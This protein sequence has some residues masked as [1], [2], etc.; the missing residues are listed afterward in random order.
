MAKFIVKAYAN[1][2]YGLKGKETIID[3]LSLSEAK[4]KAY[5]MFDEYEEIGVWLESEVT[6]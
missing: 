2:E 6:E 3:A 4:R 5:Q 1:A